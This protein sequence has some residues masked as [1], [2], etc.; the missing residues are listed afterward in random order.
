[1]AS[2]WA[3]TDPNPSPE[4]LAVHLRY[5]K[6]QNNINATPSAQY[7]AAA[8]PSNQG[9]TALRRARA[10]GG[11]TMRWTLIRSAKMHQKRQFVKNRSLIRTPRREQTA[12][13][14][15]QAVPIPKE[16][17]QQTTAIGRDRSSKRIEPKRSQKCVVHAPLVST[18]ATCNS[19][20]H[21][22]N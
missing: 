17:N 3:S 15:I 12:P 18:E 16:N 8:K 6:T 4:A 21:L 9:Y 20:H 22:F 19:N 11:T 5:F 14:T 13:A 7:F 2:K 1:M 10:D